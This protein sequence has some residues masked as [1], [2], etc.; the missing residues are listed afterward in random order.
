[1]PDGLPEK[2]VL[3]LRGSF[4]QKMTSP[5]TPVSK[6]SYFPV[7]VLSL[8]LREGNV[9]FNPFPPKG[10]TKLRVPCSSLFI[11]KGLVLDDGLPVEN[12]R[13]CCVGFT[14]FIRVAPSIE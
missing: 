12:H 13:L 7:R 4:L 11:S 3:F 9:I 10:A 8:G 5:V 14:K 1:M 6:F 2:T